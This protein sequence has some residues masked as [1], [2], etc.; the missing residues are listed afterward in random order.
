MRSM[1]LEHS[2]GMVL[3]IIVLV[4]AL[5]VLRFAGRGKS[6]LGKLVL[7]LDVLFLLVLVL[8][9]FDFRLSTLV[10][11]TVPPEADIYLDCSRSA[12]GFRAFHQRALAH[13][14][15]LAAMLEQRGYRPVLHAF[16]RYRMGGLP[17]LAEQIGRASCRERV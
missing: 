4:A 7:V 14:S 15:N 12:T 8:F 11:A 17:G 6:R 3:L 16:G 10:T 5:G 2:G 9:F 13:Y 1:F